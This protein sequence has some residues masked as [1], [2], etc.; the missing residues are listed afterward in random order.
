MSISQYVIGGTALVAA[1][2]VGYAKWTERGAKVDK[3]EAR[4]A[5]AKAECVTDLADDVTQSALQQV[6][7]LTAEVARQKAIAAAEAKKSRQRLDAYNALNRKINNVPE[8]PPVPDAIEL[9]LD[10][11]RSAV[12]GTTGTDR[13][14]E[15]G[16]E[17]EAADPRPNLPAG[18]EPAPEAPGS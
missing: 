18:T 7:T 15:N 3:A 1:L 8:N 9:V 17:G 5:I 14:H 13:A 4:T 11:M 12:P 6:T 2:A 10:R 16:S